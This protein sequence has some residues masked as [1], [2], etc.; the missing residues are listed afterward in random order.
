MEAGVT[1]RRIYLPKG[2]RWKDAYTKK[3]Y[4]GGQYVTVPAPIDIILVMMRE[5]KEY[6]IYT[7]E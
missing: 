7:E 1:E 6:P 4:E 2:T 3:V 5:G